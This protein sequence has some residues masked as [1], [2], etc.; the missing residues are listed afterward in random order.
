MAWDIRLN[1]IPKDWHQIPV[2]FRKT[3]G[4]RDGDK[5]R[6]LYWFL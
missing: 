4:I 3:N 6:S 1:Q 2:R 5:E